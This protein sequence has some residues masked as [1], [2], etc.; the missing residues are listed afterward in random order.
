MT[1]QLA[2]GAG[3]G[4][5]GTA[6]AVE[7]AGGRSWIGAAVG[8]RSSGAVLAL[9]GR[10]RRARAFGTAGIARLAGDGSAPVA[11]A[12]AGGRLAVAAGP[13]P[14]RGCAVVVLDA[15]SGRR[16]AQGTLAPLAGGEV[17]GCPGAEVSSLASAGPGRL[18]AGGSGGACPA[19]VAVHDA[20]LASVGVL[21]VEG[22]E[23]TAVASAGPPLDVCV[24]VE[25]DGRVGLRRLAVASA[26]ADGE[27]AGPVPP[28][29]QAGRLAAVTSLG[30]TGCA[31]LAGARAGAPAQVLQAA[32][33]AAPAATALPAGFRPGTLFR[34]RRHVLVVG[35]RRAG[36]RERGAVAVVPIAR[37]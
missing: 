31:A 27:V 34:C 10:G 8:S 28:S 25:R 36:G 15:R 2:R 18:I 35:T 5:R 19:R 4:S 33:E 37:S 7:P 32:G 16:G 6:V 12:A 29:V 23:R 9:D 14:C 26:G 21:P 3:A 30:R 24:A 1:V 17:A 13:A 11:L 22:A 20:G